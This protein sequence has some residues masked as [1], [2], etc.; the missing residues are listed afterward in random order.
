MPKRP[1]RHTN[2]SGNLVSV[3]ETLKRVPFKRRRLYQLL[4]RKAIRARKDGR[5]TLV[6]MVSVERYLNNLPDYSK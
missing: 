5:K 4:K 1:R 2:G 3:E 6:D